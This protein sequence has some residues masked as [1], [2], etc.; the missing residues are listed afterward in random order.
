MFGIRFLYVMEFARYKL[1]D[2]AKR[3]KQPGDSLRLVHRTMEMLEPIAE[4]AEPVKL[5]LA[6]LLQRHAS[7]LRESIDARVKINRLEVSA[8]EGRSIGLV[9][10]GKQ[11]RPVLPGQPLF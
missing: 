6:V 3:V 1:D 7:N 4:C 9:D 11:K 2:K 10:I 8:L 5:L